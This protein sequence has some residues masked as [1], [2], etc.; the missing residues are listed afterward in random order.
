MS[1]PVLGAPPHAVAVPTHFFKVVLGEKQ[2]GRGFATAGFILPNKVIPENKDLRDFQ[3]PLDVIE[4]QAGLLFFDKVRCIAFYLVQSQ[5]LHA[6]PLTFYV[7]KLGYRDSWM[8]QKRLIC[9][10]K[11]SVPLV[12]RTAGLRLLTKCERNKRHNALHWT[13]W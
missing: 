7:R 3:A 8:V 2:G 9:V 11:P 6:V 13:D 10:A 4:K 5:L 12:P 1:Y